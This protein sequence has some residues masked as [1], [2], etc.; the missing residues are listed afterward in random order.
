MMNN[1][2]IRNMAN[3]MAEDTGLYELRNPIVSGMQAKGLFSRILS[4][5]RRR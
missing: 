2:M 3:Q 5:I 4:R 1:M